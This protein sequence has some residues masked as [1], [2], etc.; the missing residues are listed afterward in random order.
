[1]TMTDDLRLREAWIN[2]P[3]C[4]HHPDRPAIVSNKASLGTTGCISYLSVFHYC[5]SCA[6]HFLT[7]KGTDEYTLTRDEVIRGLLGR[8]VR[9]ELE[10]GHTEQGRFVT[11]QERSF[12][13]PD[14]PTLFTYEVMWSSLRTPYDAKPRWIN[15]VDISRIEIISEFA[16]D[17]EGVFS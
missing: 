3:V 2:S 9:I 12:T 14:K 4:D 8:K 16:A 7:P 13:A 10:R 17:A 11:V 15:V 6:G 1:M 5:G